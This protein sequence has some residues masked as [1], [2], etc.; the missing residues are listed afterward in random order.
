MLT[1]GVFAST[2]EDMIFAVS[3]LLLWFLYCC[4]ELWWF[5]VY[6]LVAGLV[7]EILDEKEGI[8]FYSV[9]VCI[10]VWGRGRGGG[11]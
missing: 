9:H 11:G 2:A 5:S 7:L 4:E 10:S 3:Y 8:M 1:P 6:K